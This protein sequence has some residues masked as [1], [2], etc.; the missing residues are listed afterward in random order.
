SEDF[1][2]WAFSKIKAE[3]IVYRVAYVPDLITGLKEKMVECTCTACGATF[4]QQY[5]TDPLVVNYK[6]SKIAWLDNNGNVVTNKE[7]ALCPNCG[8]EIVSLHIGS[9]KDEYIIASYFPGE[10]ILVDGLPALVQWRIVRSVDK[11][12]KAK[13]EITPCDAYIFTKRKALRYCGYEHGFFSRIIYSDTWEAK[14]NSNDKI[15]RLSPDNIFPFDEKTLQG[16]PLENAK[17]SKYLSESYPTNCFPCTYF[18]TYLRHKQVE[19]LVM[20]GLSELVNE[21]IYANSNFQNYYT[22]PSVKIPSQGINWKSKKPHEMLGLTKEE[23]RVLKNQKWNIDTL[24]LYKC[25]KSHCKSVSAESFKSDFKGYDKYDIQ[26]IVTRYS[27]P[28]KFI[29][30][31]NKQRKKYRNADVNLALD[32]FRIAEKLNIDVCGERNF[33]P[34]NLRRAHDQLVEQLNEN[35]EKLKKEKEAKNTQSFSEL[36]EKY[37]DFEFHKNGLMI[38]IAASPDEL[39]KEGRELSHC[40]ASYI[41]KHSQ[42]ESCIFLIRRENQPDKPFYTLELDM[43]RKK[44]LQ[45][46]GKRNCERTDEVIAFEEDW[47]K[48]LKGVKQH[49]RNG[50]TKKQRACA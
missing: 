16:T 47:L 1:K 2:K 15:M 35:K 31:L 30:Y 20:Q 44:V 23:F 6:Q 29:R 21:I 33:Y 4:Y 41:N 39:R 40:V 3:A 25:V 32:C 19:N 26:K 38:R 42:G 24:E 28:Y 9:I 50:H 7:H 5:A 11:S 12:G 37:A 27:N 22:A 48:Y 49:G 36:R 43:K 45:N 13:T 18:R 17:F 14:S 34:Q 10:L 46:R 8:A